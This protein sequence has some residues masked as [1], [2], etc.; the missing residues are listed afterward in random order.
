MRPQPKPGQTLIARTAEPPGSAESRRRRPQHRQPG[1]CLLLRF[2]RR[3]SRAPAAC[4]RQS[5]TSHGG[6]SGC[7]R[8]DSG[9]ADSQAPQV[10]TSQP[11]PLGRWP[12]MGCEFICPCCWS[13]CCPGG[14]GGPVGPCCPCTACCGTKPWGWYWPGAITNGM[15][16]IC[17]C[18]LPPNFGMGPMPT[19][20]AMEL[21]GC[22]AIMVCWPK[23][24]PCC[25]ACGAQGAPMV[26]GPCGPGVQGP[27]LTLSSCE[28]SITQ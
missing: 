1:A 26:S 16:T 9:H 14:P 22:W 7:A 13:A 20:T 25:P 27:T 21:L 15:T 2:R 18:W 6:R 5:F 17:C 23:T 28:V 24:T 11:A 8:H 3:S 10:V 12:Y 19:G 4:G